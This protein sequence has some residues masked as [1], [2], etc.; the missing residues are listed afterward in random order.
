MTLNSQLQRMKEEMIA[1][2]ENGM[3]QIA[4]NWMFIHLDYCGFRYGHKL[5]CQESFY[6]ALLT[7]DINY[8]FSVRDLEYGE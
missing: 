5:T 3:K 8:D 2:S 4:R 7:A 6:C 1:E